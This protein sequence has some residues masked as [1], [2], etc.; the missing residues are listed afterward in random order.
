MFAKL[1]NKIA[2]PVAVFDS[3]NR[4]TNER[5]SPTLSSGAKSW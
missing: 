1:A 3:I 2:F 4:V 5:R